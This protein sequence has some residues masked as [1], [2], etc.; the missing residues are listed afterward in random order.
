MKNV[1]VK[2]IKNIYWNHL[3]QSE[4]KIIFII[5]KSN[6]DICI[7]GLEFIISTF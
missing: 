6:F 1:F 5:K 7:V 3:L 2:N 4:Y